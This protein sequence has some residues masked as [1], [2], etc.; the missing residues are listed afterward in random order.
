[1]EGTRTV[2]NARGRLAGLAGLDLA[3]RVPVVTPTDG[4]GS[5]LA[6]PLVSLAFGVA[7]VPLL[8]TLTT[9]VLVGYAATLVA[10][11]AYP[12]SFELPVERWGFRA[13]FAATTVATAAL[14]AGYVDSNPLPA[15]LA[16]LTL[17]G[18]A[19]VTFLLYLR[20]VV[21]WN[22][23]ATDSRYL[24]LY[25]GY[26]WTDDVEDV[27]RNFERSG[28]LHRP[29]V[30]L[31]RLVAGL[32][33]AFPAFVAGFVTVVLFR[34]YPLPDLLIL[35]WALGSVAGDALDREF[36]PGH[37]PLDIESQLYDA[38]SESVRNATGMVLTLYL[39]ASSFGFVSLLTVP[40]AVVLAG[41]WE[42]LA[43]WVAPRATWGGVGVVV[44]LATSSLYG[45][46][47]CLRMLTRLPSH[48][49]VN[50]PDTSA[51]DDSG[52]AIDPRNEASE[53]S[54]PASPDDSVPVRPVGFTLPPLAATVA[55]GLALFWTGVES[56]CLAVT[57]PLA[58]VLLAVSLLVT[59]NR[60]RTRLASDPHYVVFGTA[61]FLVAAW[62]LAHA[63]PLRDAIVGRD[64]TLVPLP[65][66]VL[67]VVFVVWLGYLGDVYRYTEVHDD[68]RRYAG[69]AYFLA[70]AVVLGTLSVVTPPTHSLYHV[71]VA[72]TA[73]GGVALALTAAFDTR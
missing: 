49:R 56:V 68:H 53:R 71:S 22:L 44:V 63:D 36:S 72:V 48:L 16:S 54:G 20:D 24:G 29:A 34:A 57:W 55:V 33:V 26:A 5:D 43:P 61:A 65:E 60:V 23:S 45:L 50:A 7:D 8:A 15:F 28:W 1:M 3:W 6:V 67:F 19:G 47:C 4:S 25:R 46:W 40:G 13:V 52:D 64:I 32:L 10:P 38:A 69:S 35:S 42:L 58:L 27:R 17:V 9:W 30:A 11:L 62:T 70:F 21:G 59:R 31:N 12:S 2:R 66:L 51:S 73:L 41:G 37:R 39:L 18:I 14:F